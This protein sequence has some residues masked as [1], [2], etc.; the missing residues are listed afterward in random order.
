M[1]VVFLFVEHTSRF[2]LVCLCVSQNFAKLTLE[3]NLSSC[4][5]CKS[6]AA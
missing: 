6:P 3:F 5:C 4:D 1:Y 2:F